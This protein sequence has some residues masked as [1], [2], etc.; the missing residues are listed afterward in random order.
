L[1]SELLWTARVQAAPPAAVAN[2]DKHSRLFISSPSLVHD[3]AAPSQ[4]NVAAVI[5]FL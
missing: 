2:I 5:L 3:N 1:N 4:Q